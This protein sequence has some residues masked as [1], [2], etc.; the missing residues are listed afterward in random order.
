[1]IGV[2]GG[3][4]IVVIFIAA[5]VG[6]VYISEEQ[7]STITTGVLIDER[8]NEINKESLYVENNSTAVK[9]IN[10]AQNPVDIVEYRLLDNDGNLLCV[11]DAGDLLRPGAEIE[12]DPMNACI[13]VY[14]NDDPDFT[15]CQ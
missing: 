13:D 14:L 11:C 9:V 1:M 10:R 12:L 15:K 6:F 8:N 3:I 7:N 4:I 2:I 5:I